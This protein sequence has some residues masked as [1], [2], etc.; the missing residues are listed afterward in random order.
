[1][2]DCSF[3]C[4]REATRLLELP[5]A[6]GAW[7]AACGPCYAGL[8]KQCEAGTVIDFADLDAFAD[9]FVDPN[10]EEPS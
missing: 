9:R 10:Q 1:M 5:H 3:G 7:A 6:D 2:T 4:D 8:E